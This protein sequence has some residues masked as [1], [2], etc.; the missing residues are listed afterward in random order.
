MN[1]L[2][3]DCNSSFF[4]NLYTKVKEYMSIID[5]YT[6]LVSAFNC[7][8]TFTFFLN[9]KKVVFACTSVHIEL[10][11]VAWHFICWIKFREYVFTHL[12]FSSPVRVSITFSS[13]F[14]SNKWKQ[15]N[16]IILPVILLVVRVHVRIR[17]CQCFMLFFSSNF[18]S[19]FLSSRCF[20]THCMWKQNNAFYNIS[21]IVCRWGL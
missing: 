19:N 3:Y 17:Q 5:T 6:L 8:Y 21:S 9:K 1:V 10:L 14:T 12:Q 7:N 11:Y 2:V 13:S 15:K 16:I 20:F 4:F 18:Y